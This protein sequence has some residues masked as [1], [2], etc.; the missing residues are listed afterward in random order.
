MIEQFQFTVT[1]PGRK[2]IDITNDVANFVNQ[3]KI[4]IYDLGNIIKG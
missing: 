1:T 2:I 4:Q 3:T